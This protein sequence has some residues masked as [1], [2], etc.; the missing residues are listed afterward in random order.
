MT[1]Y[2][3]GT[4]EILRDLNEHIINKE[5]FSTVR[6]GD[7]CYG[8]VASY[9]CPDLIVGGKWSGGQDN[10]IVQS[11]LRQLGV[12]VQ[13]RFD[14]VKKVV[15]AAN[16]AN[17]IDSYDA[18]LTELSPRQVGP[19]ASKWKE[20]H[21]YAGIGNVSYCSP[22]LH[23]FSVV[24]NEYNL[25][26]VMKKRTIFCI[27]H[28]V[29]ITP[30]LRIL[31][32]AKEIHSYQIPRRGKKLHYTKHFNYIVNLIEEEATNYDLFLIGA[33]LLGKIYCG[34][35]KEHGGRAFDAGR[36]FDL[37]AG[38]RHIDSRPKRLI[39]MNTTKLLCERIRN[40]NGKVW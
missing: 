27:S 22:F 2:I 17:Y 5:P 35:I 40:C 1:E 10:K 28:N 3:Y 9:F 23:Y 39:K 36:L 7:G 18:F 25:F 20:I 14:I 31:S 32:N 4:E 6:F 13:N 29:Y 34:L 37:W 38:K 26:D 16:N 8:I 15:W 19:L 21:K 12:P 11:V 30:K 24:E 33:G